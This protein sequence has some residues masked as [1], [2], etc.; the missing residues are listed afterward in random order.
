MTEP[1]NEPVPPEALPEDAAKAISALNRP[2]LRAAIDFAQRRDRYLRPEATNQIEPGPGEEIVRIEERPSH[3]LVAKL[4]PCADGCSDCPH[5]PYLY[6]V[7]EVTRPDG[8][9]RLHWS[10]IGPDET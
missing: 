9:S 8:D 3:T 2:E 4:Q 1:A 5:G 10:Y 7:R 6:H